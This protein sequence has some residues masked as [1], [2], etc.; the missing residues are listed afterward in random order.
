MNRFPEHVLINLN[1]IAKNRQWKYYNNNIKNSIFPRQWILIGK[2]T[3]IIKFG[4]RVIV[5]INMTTTNHYVFNFSGFKAF[6]YFID[7][8]EKQQ[9]LLH[10]K[11]H[12]SK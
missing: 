6:Y 3:N 7:K 1:G 5:I 8:L 10:Y 12:I 9:N 2:E 4:T 11:F